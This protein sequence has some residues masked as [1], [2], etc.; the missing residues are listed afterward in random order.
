MIIATVGKNASGKDNFLEY[1]AKKY[2]IKILSIG[3]IARELAEIEGLEKTREN[4]HMI[5]QKYMT[6]YGQ[7]FFPNEII[8]KIRTMD[9]KNIM[10]SGIRPLSDVKTFKGIFGDEFI[11]VRVVVEDDKIRFDRTQSRRSD[12]DPQSYDDFLKYDSAEEKLFQTSQTMK[13]AD[14]EIVSGGSNEDYCAVLD[15]FC[16]EV[17]LKCL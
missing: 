8:K 17:L 2:G 6:K 3:D 4:L 10:V 7:A 16:D 5:S 14:Y 1:I 13:L 15:R 12:R 11:L 9:E